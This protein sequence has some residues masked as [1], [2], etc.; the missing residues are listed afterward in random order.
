MLNKCKYLFI[1]GAIASGIGK[2]TINSSIGMLLKQYGYK[3]S[4]LKIDPYLNI[5]AGTM[6]P[7]EHGE[8]FVTGDGGEV[9]LD[10]GNY[11]RFLDIELSFYHSLTSGK[12]YQKILQKEREG[13]YL[14]KTVQVI[15]HVVDEIKNWIRH[16]TTVPLKHDTVEKPDILLVEVGGTVGDLESTCYYEAVRQM[17]NEEGKDNV[18]LIMLT[19]IL[20]LNN[21]QKTKPAQNGIKDLRYTGLIA[22]FIICRSE[23]ELQI[24]QR[25]KLAMFGNISKDSIFSVPNSQHIYDVPE[26][27][28]KQKLAEHILDKFKL[29]LQKVPNIQQYTKFGQ[30]LKELEQQKPVTVGIMGKYMKNLDAYMSLIK[31]LKEA[32]YSIKVNLQLKYI[33]LVEFQNSPNPEE[34]LEKECDQFDAILVPGGFGF[35][36]FNLKIKCCQYAREKKKPFLGICYG[37]QAAV[38]EYAQNILGVKD[39][40]SEELKEEQVGTNFVVFMPEINPKLFGGNMR[41]GNHETFIENKESIAYQIYESEVVEERHRHR[42]EVNPEKIQTL[43]EKGLIFSGKDKKTGSRMEIL[44][45]P[46]D[47]HPFYVGV[48]YHPEFTSKNFKPNPLFVSFVSAAANGEYR[49]SKIDT[50]YNNQI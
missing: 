43:N 22:D 11:E 38:I 31:A 1:C 34:Q 30:Y 37:F 42:Y 48:Q 17:I 12:L 4:F 7:Y 26:V 41:L 25:D 2:G 46:K 29:P 6:N 19:Y 9:D 44:E 24:Q 33:D 10:I 50:N 39:A 28:Q 15:P 23:T 18:G 36:G 21:E 45:L 20:T 16:L 8:V 5:D 13:H 14:G 47:Q 32:S 3:V 27:L 40:T 35:N 49:K